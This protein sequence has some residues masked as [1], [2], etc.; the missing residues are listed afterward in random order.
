M[1]NALQLRTTSIF[2]KEHL[3]RRGK[4][5]HVSEYIVQYDHK[6]LQNSPQVLKY[7]LKIWYFVGYTSIQIRDFQN[8]YSKNWIKTRELLKIW[9]SAIISSFPVC[10]FNHSSIFVHD[11]KNYI[12]VCI[13]P[14]TFGKFKQLCFL[15]FLRVEHIFLDKGSWLLSQFW[16]FAAVSRVF[17]IVKSFQDF[18]TVRYRYCRL[19]LQN[20]G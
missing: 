14:N 20:E 3:N 4:L 15:H 18:C 10:A 8:M 9:M 5:L 12:T 2:W 11:G 16:N 17:S 6:I 13:L 1:E 7:N 19:I